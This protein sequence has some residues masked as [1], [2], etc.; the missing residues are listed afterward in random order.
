MPIPERNFGTQI[1]INS[2][3]CL[4]N[5]TSRATVNYGTEI[6]ILRS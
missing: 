2:K 3:L 5:I 4:H 1:I 6:W